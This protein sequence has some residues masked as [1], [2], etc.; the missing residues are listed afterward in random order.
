MRKTIVWRNGEKGQERRG[1]VRRQLRW[2]NGEREII[3]EARKVTGACGGVV[4]R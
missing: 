2:G 4:L 3:R 1:T